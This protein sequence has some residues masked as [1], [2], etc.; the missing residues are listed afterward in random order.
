MNGQFP[1]LSKANFKPNAEG[2]LAN[3]RREGT[4]DRVYNFELSQDNQI[5][6]AVIKEF[7]LA[8]GLSQDDPAFD[9]KR[10][11]AFM[12]FCGYDYARAKYTGMDMPVYHNIA[13]DTAEALANP[14]GRQFMEE[15]RGP[16]TNWQEFEQYPWPDPNTPAAFREY[17]WYSK[18]LPDDMCIVGGQLSHFCEDLCFLMGYETLCYALFDQPDLVAAIYEKQLEFYRVLAR[19]TVQFDRV[20]CI[21]GSDDMGFK[22]GTL[23]SP[24][25][26]R[27]YVL[28][29]HKEIARITH[30][31]GKLYLLHCCGQLEQIMEDL[32][33]DVGIDAKHSYEDTITPV[34]QMKGLYGD[35]VAILGGIDMDFIC[36]AD[37]QAIRQRVRKTLDV[38]MPGGGYCLGTGNTVA[39]YVPLKNYLAML[40]EGRQ[41]GQ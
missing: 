3:L 31:A 35:R 24:E 14:N 19:R 39:N 26:L 29:G 11:I 4:P 5:K 18:N 6:E 17:E 7:G 34:T 25:T 21:W 23:L 8:K 40:D 33:E 37:E 32:I 30:Q 13:P 38:C 41:Y 1:A 16:V 22:T 2:L 10:E 15:H 9:M 36:R 27:K 12:R 20:R 28:P